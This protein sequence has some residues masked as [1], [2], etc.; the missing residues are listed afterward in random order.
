M[1]NPLKYRLD[2]PVRLST[3]A[4]LS[5]GLA[6]CSLPQPAKANWNPFQ[7]CAAELLNTTITPEEISVACAEALEPEDLSHCVLKINNFTPVDARSALRSCFRVR[8]PLE[9]ASCVTDITEELQNYDRV[10]VTFEVEETTGIVEFSG[11]GLP[12]NT[13]SVEETIA[14]QAIATL[15]HCRRSLLPLRYAECTI[16][17]SREID[18]SPAKALET[19]L[20]AEDFPPSLFP[21]LGNKLGGKS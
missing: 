17:L 13:P 18:F 11:I 10:G 2:R 12:V 9:L 15:N 3:A 14:S 4:F 8:R 16:G 1:H 5:A 6:L 20:D 21:R 19:C 7:I